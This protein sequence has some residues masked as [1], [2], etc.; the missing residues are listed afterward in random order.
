MFPL[1]ARRVLPG[2]TAGGRSS[3]IVATPATG[4]TT[5]ATTHCSSPGPSDR[6]TIIGPSLRP[7]YAKRP[8]VQFHSICRERSCGVFRCDVGNE[9]ETSGAP[10]PAIFYDGRLFHGAPLAEVTADR[11]GIRRERQ[12]GDIEL[13]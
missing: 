6:K 8:A 1:A 12:I 4:P 5:R 10:G 9:P 7:Q 13:G 2:V 3:H 11:V